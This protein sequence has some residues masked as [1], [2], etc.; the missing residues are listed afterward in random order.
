MSDLKLELTYNLKDD[1]F[2]VETNM[3][4]PIKHVTEWLRTQIGAGADQTERNDK[5][6]YSIKLEIDL[7]DDTYTVSH[8][9]GNK[10]LRDGI[11]MHFTKTYEMA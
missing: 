10:G 1:E 6:V 2:K 8:D 7:S 4:D 11:L 9:C 5:E 3:K